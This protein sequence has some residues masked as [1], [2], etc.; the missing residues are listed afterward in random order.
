MAEVFVNLLESAQLLQFLSAVVGREFFARLELF[1]PVP[2][3]S[4][5]SGSAQELEQ[6]EARVICRIRLELKHR[7]AREGRIREP[8]GTVELATHKRTVGVMRSHGF[9]QRLK[10]VLEKR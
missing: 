1:V 3:H 7:V 5:Q 10:L 9:E 4:H 8:R 6:I 2:R